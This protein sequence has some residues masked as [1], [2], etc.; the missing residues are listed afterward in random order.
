MCVCVGGGGDQ[1]VRVWINQFGIIHKCYVSLTFQTH[2]HCIQMLKCTVDSNW[3]SL[4]HPCLDPLNYFIHYYSTWSISI[5]G[6]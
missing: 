6:H 1:S 3:M 2:A 5:H 4:L